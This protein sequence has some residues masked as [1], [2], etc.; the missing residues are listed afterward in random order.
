MA[1]NADDV[2][3]RIGPDR[4]RCPQLASP[5]ALLIVSRQRHRESRG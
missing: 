3:A 4:E 1:L 5:P 2:I